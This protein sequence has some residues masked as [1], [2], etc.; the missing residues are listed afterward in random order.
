MKLQRQQIKYLYN[1]TQWKTENIS[2]HTVAE[3]KIL[4]EYSKRAVDTGNPH[5]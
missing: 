1:G 3:I 4:L 5:I 2:Y